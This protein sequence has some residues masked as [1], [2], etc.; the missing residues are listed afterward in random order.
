MYHKVSNNHDHHV[1]DDALGHP[2]HLHAVPHGF[3]PLSAEHSEHNEE[4][5]KE[6][7][8]VPARQRAVF[9][10]LAHT[11]LVALPKQL[12]AH[13]GEDEHDYGQ[14]QCQVA[15]GPDR[16]TNNFDQGVQCGPGLGQLEDSQ[17]KAGETSYCRRFGCLLT[18]S[19]F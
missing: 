1:E 9:R 3:Y 4:R 5:M 14:H 17:L 7:T 12:H 19:A 2:S 15:Q 16:V 13:Y 10:D 8:H 18:P 6:V 11:V